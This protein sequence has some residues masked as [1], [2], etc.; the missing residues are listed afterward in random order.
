MHRNRMG[1]VS[2]CATVA[3]PAARCCRCRRLITS[4]RLPSRQGG[5]PSCSFRHTA[6]YAV[7]VLPGEQ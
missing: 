6:Y 5:C 1:A 3:C 7:G 2:G 4:R